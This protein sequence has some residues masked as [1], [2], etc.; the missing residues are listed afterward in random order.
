MRTYDDRY[1]EAELHL[2]F[3]LAG[4][5]ELIFAGCFDLHHL[6]E[7]AGFMDCGSGGENRSLRSII[8]YPDQA[9]SQRPVARRI[10][11][12]QING[13]SERTR[14]WYL[15]AQ[16]RNRHRAYCVLRHR[17]VCRNEVGRVTDQQSLGFDR[18][19][20]TAKAF[21]IG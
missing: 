11:V 7:N 14:F 1:L 16:H 10:G 5:V 2:I 4:K 13:Y 9:Q 3:I 17:I 19:R 6:S 8:L 18:A 12:E 20:S 15:A 21:W